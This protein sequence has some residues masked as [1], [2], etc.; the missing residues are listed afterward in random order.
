MKQRLIVNWSKQL[1]L[2]ISII[3]S[4]SAVF[5]QDKTKNVEND[6]KII[7]LEANK[8]KDFLSV[9]SI[10]FDGNTDSLWVGDRD[11]KT[12]RFIFSADGILIQPTQSIVLPKN[13]EPITEMNSTESGNRK[14][15]VRGR[16]LYMLN[17]DEWQKLVEPKPA[18]NS[19]SIP[20]LWSLA[21]VNKQKV[22]VVGVYLLN[23]A[24]DLDRKLILCNN[25]IDKN[26]ENWE[27]PDT[28][29]EEQIHLTQI[30][31]ADEK[32][33]WTVGTEGTIWRTK[34]GGENW[35]KQI[36]NTSETLQSVFFLNEKEGWAVGNNGTILFTENR[37]EQW[38]LLKKIIS[39]DKAVKLRSVKFSKDNEN[40]WFIGDKGTI[41]H[42]KDGGKNWSA[43]NL[44]ALP[45]LKRV[46]PETL[47][48]YELQI[49]KDYCW[50]VGSKGL[51]LRIKYDSVNY[52][53][54]FNTRPRRINR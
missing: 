12:T 6:L 41:F 20:E 51:V 44:T 53:N 46:N 43:I 34:D 54:S 40:G 33:G 16:S 48:F 19:K 9:L 42:T 18:F 8:G 17:I 30:F 27:Q 35:N 13:P 29:D 15:L 45:E 36:S 31:F 14:F 37:G 22:C 3:I 24:R 26:T 38:E 39:K 4:L 28:P 2:I 25:D 21:F 23:E 5:G 52:P 1:V 7:N 11:G 50:V 10:G 32:N 47:N 49:D